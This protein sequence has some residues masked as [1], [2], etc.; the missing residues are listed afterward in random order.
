MM[1]I[2]TEKWLEGN[3][4]ESNTN[5]FRHRSPP[6]RLF[7]YLQDWFHGILSCHVR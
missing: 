4:K 3:R 6:G 1:V 2:H 7:I 5:N